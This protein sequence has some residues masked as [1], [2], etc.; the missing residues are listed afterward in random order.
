MYYHNTEAY[1]ESCQTFR[2][3]VYENSSW[4]KAV[5]YL[6]KRVLSKMF[7]MILN[8]LL[9]KIFNRDRGKYHITNKK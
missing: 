3:E 8:T 6:R 7:D 2:M 1:L 4:L 5:N 9:L